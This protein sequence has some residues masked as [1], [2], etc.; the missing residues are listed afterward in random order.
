[1]LSKSAVSFQD[2]V[3]SP[4]TRHSL[5]R[6]RFHWISQ[7]VSCGFNHPRQLSSKASVILTLLHKWLLQ[8]QAPSVTFALNIL[9]TSPESVPETTQFSTLNTIRRIRLPVFS[10]ETMVRL[11][12]TR[13]WV[14][15]WRVISTGRRTRWCISKWSHSTTMTPSRRFRRRTNTIT[16]LLR[17]LRLRSGKEDWE[18]VVAR[19]P[20]RT[21]VEALPIL[22]PI[23]KSFN[24]H[25]CSDVREVVEMK[26]LTT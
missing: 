12:T 11:T 16:H 15:S 5:R 3:S 20:N 26:L 19:E 22:S 23:S 2:C 18:R 8:F 17:R 24:Q 9:M 25:F 7:S 14:T 21:P 1:M 13:T 6:S 10:A 4:S